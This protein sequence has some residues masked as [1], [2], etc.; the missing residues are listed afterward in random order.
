MYKQPKVRDNEFKCVFDQFINDINS[1]YSNEVIV[2]DLNINMSRQS[3]CL[4][5]I[6]NIITSVICYKNAIMTMINVI[7]NNQ[8]ERLPGVIT[9]DI[10][11]SDF[12]LTS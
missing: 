12:D 4:N 10:R 6:M 5:E 3:H 2:G 1:K 9:S 7:I 8:P 11:L